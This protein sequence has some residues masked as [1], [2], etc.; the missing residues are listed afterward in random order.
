MSE[1]GMFGSEESARRWAEMFTL[2]V[3]GDLKE[4]GW[5]RHIQAM[6]PMEA[7]F[8]SLRI[9]AE[10]MEQKN[11]AL[12]ERVR[13]LELQVQRLELNGAKSVEEPIPIKTWHCSVAR[14]D[15]KGFLWRVNGSPIFSPEPQEGMWFSLANVARMDDDRA[16]NFC[17]EH[18]ASIFLFERNDD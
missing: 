7:Q 6:S 9:R 16:Y 11:D 14:C 10:N 18:V 13:Q 1:Q 4:D 15:N 3:E 8:E 12:K 5:M 17:P 2:G